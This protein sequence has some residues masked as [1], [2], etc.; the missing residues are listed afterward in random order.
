MV[1]KVDTLAGGAGFVLVTGTVALGQQSEKSSYSS[2]GAG[3]A[4]VSAPG[5]NDEIGAGCVNEILST[6]PGGWGCFQGTSMAAPHT[7]GVAAL[8]ISQFGT[9]NNN[10]K[11]VMSPDKV[12]SR[13]RSTAIDIGKKGIDKCFGYGR[14]DALRA[15]KNDTSSKYDAP[16]PFC[17]EYTE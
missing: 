14:I 4:D 13:L 6:I 11:W 15:V 3:F 8:I 5:G 16:A 12:A 17:P 10:G 9:L 7:T 2:W 1:L